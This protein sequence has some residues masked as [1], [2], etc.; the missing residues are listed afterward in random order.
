MAEALAT[1]LAPH[2]GEAPG[3]AF[4]VWLA[5][6]DLGA[7]AAMGLWAEAA[8]HGPAFA[9]PLLFPWAL[10]SAL[11]AHLAR[12]LDLRGP[13]VSLVGGPEASVAAFGF[14]LDALDEGEVERALLLRVEARLGRAFVLVLGAG[15]GPTLQRLNVPDG[16]GG[17]PLLGLA[18]CPEP[19]GVIWSLPPWGS[20]RLAATSAAFGV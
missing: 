20:V 18:T 13:N 11:A 19:F 4:G 15:E 17:D 14:A 1:S 16:R 7:D 10:T 12:R 5:A 2:R 8:T 6:E 3:H 9:N